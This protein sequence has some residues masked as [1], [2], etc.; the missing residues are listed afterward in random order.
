MSAAEEEL[1]AVVLEKGSEASRAAA[2]DRM[3]QLYA[4]G[5]KI[6]EATDIDGTKAPLVDDPELSR[7]HP[8]AAKGAQMSLR[9]KNLRMVAIT[10]GELARTSNILTA[11]GLSEM[12]RFS[13]YGVQ[14]LVRDRSG[15]MVEQ[16]HPRLDEATHAL[17]EARGIIEEELRHLMGR[18]EVIAWKEAG[19]SDRA[20]K[21]GILYG[22][23]K[24]NMVAFHYAQGARK[25]GA[26]KATLEEALANVKPQLD[27]LGL[28]LKDNNGNIE[29]DFDLGLDKGVI[30]EE[31][32]TD[33]DAVIFLCDDKGDL[34][35]ARFVRQ[36]GEQQDKIGIVAA[37][38]HGPEYT[39]GEDGQQKLK[40]DGSPRELMEI[41]DVVFPSEAALGQ[42]MQEVVQRA[43]ELNPDCLT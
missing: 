6:L 13:S 41:A 23:P 35:G 39:I 8:A 7:F 38:Y 19:G 43:W 26:L 1:P 25:N 29:V 33:V 27:Q 37:V 9:V 15:Q 4:S 11:A 21:D 40:R 30:L 42:F 28:E 32:S 18:D 3:A 31:L 22:E 24:A 14:R 2:R 34:P 16:P 36:F 5:V 17:N 10:G 20:A 12:D